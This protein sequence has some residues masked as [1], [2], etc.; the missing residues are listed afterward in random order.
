MNKVNMHEGTEDYFGGAKGANCPLCLLPL[1]K[2]TLLLIC[3]L[4]RNVMVSDYAMAVLIIA[5]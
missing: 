4:S 1:K 5:S 3:S 2:K